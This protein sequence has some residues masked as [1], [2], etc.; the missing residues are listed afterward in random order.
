MFWER[1]SL[2]LKTAL[3]AMSFIAGEVAGFAVPCMSGLW[4]WSGFLG[5]NAMLVM[6]GWDLPSLR[7][8]VA[9]FAGLS[10]AWRSEAGRLA[11]DGRARMVAADG[12]P[13][14]YELEVESGVTHRRGRNADGSRIV[15]FRS[16]IGSI[17]VRVIARMDGAARP[18]SP[19]ERWRCS[20]WLSLKKGARTRYSQRTL[21]VLDKGHMSKVAAAK[22]PAASVAYRRLSGFLARNAGIGLGWNPE[23]ASLSKAMLL[24]RRGEV[25]FEK[26]QMFAVAGTVH[27]FA[28]SGLHVMLVAGIV[29]KLLSMAGLSRTMKAACAIPILAAY[30]MMSGMRPSAVRAFLMV[31]LWLGA[32]LFGRRP[33]SLVAWG[34]SAIVVYGC[35]PAMVFN[36]GC[37][38]SFTVMLG[39]VLWMRWSSQFAAPLDCLL[40]KA[41]EA[42]S[43]GED[44][45]KGAFAWWYRA[46]MWLLGALG[47]SFA[48]WIASTPILAR[49]FGRIAISGIFVNLAVV[50]LAAVAVAFGAV[51]I[52]AA[53]VAQPL[54]ALFNNLAAASIWLMELISGLAAKCPGAS[55]ETLEWSWTE[56]GLWYAAWIALF[57]VLARNLPRREEWM[58]VKSWR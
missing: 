37:A 50:P 44:S 11:V 7:W 4:P 49:E 2:G 28:I 9:A 24:G 53:A 46:G 51:G 25:A 42:Q 55:L 14:A 41:V 39:I 21:W 19:G 38:L 56:C 5:V 8:F 15:C 29:C 3:L 32:E 34:V 31:G 26:R 10:L 58:S 33:D 27:V 22:R 6:L 36:A 43:L 45:R 1:N 40:Q 57:A 52:A 20:G 54:G 48:A 17:P 16:S 35:S 12:S 23:L 47:I 13:P 18:P 30:V